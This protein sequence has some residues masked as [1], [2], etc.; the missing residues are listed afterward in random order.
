MSQSMTT[1]PELE[2]AR[3]LLERM[4]ITPAD[5]LEV[6]PSR[7]LSPTFAEYVPVVAAAVSDG[8]HRAYGSYW[9]RR[10]LPPTPQLRSCFPQWRQAGRR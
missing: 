1:R 10:C 5:L 7:P 6:R 2:A 9:N 8:S 4:G 3:L